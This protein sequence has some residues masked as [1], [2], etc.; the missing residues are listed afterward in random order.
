MTG[1]CIRAASALAPRVLLARGTCFGQALVP[2]T[3]PKPFVKV[4][5]TSTLLDPAQVCPPSSSTTQG[6]HLLPA[7]RLLPLAVVFLPRCGSPGGSDNP[8]TEILGRDGV[9]AGSRWAAHVAREDM[10]GSR[11]MASKGVCVCMCVHTHMSANRASLQRR[12]L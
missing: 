2:A 7:A 5:T 8:G 10:C 6:S 11:Y 4:S 1:S 12:R 9:D 3:P